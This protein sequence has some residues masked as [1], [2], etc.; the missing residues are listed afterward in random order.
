MS[1]LI[2]GARESVCQ[3]LGFYFIVVPMVIYGFSAYDWPSLSYAVFCIFPF[4]LVF[5]Y[6]RIEKIGVTKEGW[7]PCILYITACCDCCRVIM[8]CQG[9]YELIQVV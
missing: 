4:F 8:S 5:N 9:E 2:C 7:G 1:Y 3:Q 6:Q